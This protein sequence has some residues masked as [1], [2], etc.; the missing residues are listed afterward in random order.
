MLEFGCCCSFCSCS[1]WVYCCCQFCAVDHAKMP[2]YRY[3]CFFATS[4]A[5]FP[6]NQSLFLHSIY[7]I[8][9]LLLPP[10]LLLAF[11]PR[12][13]LVG[14]GRM[15]TIAPS[16]NAVPLL[17][18]FDLVVCP[19][20]SNYHRRSLHRNQIKQSFIVSSSLPKGWLSSVVILHVQPIMW[21]KCENVAFA[22]S[23][24]K[25][26][27]HILGPTKAHMLLFIP[28]QAW[29]QVRVRLAMHS[30]AK[31]HV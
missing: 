23:S 5:P 16:W 28:N 31:V 18:D 26:P 13:W 24:W 22:S 4:I 2:Q 27:L 3:R 10:L 15:R 20:R 9:R 30:G 11:I 21:R 25:L 1:K 14:S 7:Q 8:E 19:F 29:F 6:P 12:K 17:V